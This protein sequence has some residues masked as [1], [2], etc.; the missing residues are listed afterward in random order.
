[1]AT[2]EHPHQQG[3][4]KLPTVNHTGY[5]TRIFCVETVI[6]CHFTVSCTGE[7]TLKPAIVAASC[8]FTGSDE[9]TDYAYIQRVLS[10]KISV[11]K[12]HRVQRSRR[13]MYCGCVCRIFCLFWV[14]V[15]VY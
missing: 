14:F 13:C 15:N 1:M 10:L 8:V 6:V 4:S 2:K 7:I 3:S 12:F 5:Y 9:F 11:R